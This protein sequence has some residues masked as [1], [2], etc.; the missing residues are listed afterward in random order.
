MPAGGSWSARVLVNIV[1][2][3]WRWR[4]R[5]P[6]HLVDGLPDDQPT[7]RRGSGDDLRAGCSRLRAVGGPVASVPD[8]PAAAVIGR[9]TRTDNG[10]LDPTTFGAGSRIFTMET[11]SGGDVNA[12]ILSSD[13][14]TW[15]S[16]WLSGRSTTEFNG[17]ASAYP[18]TEGRPPGPVTETNG[19]SYGR[20]QFWY[21]DRFTPEVASV[22]VRA[23]G[24][25]LEA[26]A[27][28]GFVAFMRDLPGLTSD[29]EPSFEVTLYSADGTEL[30][31][32]ATARGDDTLPQAFWSWVPDEELPDGGAGR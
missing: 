23:Q 1:R 25:V 30:A 24:Q 27:V 9:C 21:V 13:G 31:G 28:D 16:C 18:M 15:G 5:R 22:S 19:M 6:E 4:H 26:R 20:G 3:D 10:A 32:K 8:D 7:M 12:V 11:S 17:Y 14:R 2:D 29:S